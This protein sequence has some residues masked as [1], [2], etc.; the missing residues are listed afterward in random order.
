MC[1]P[2]VDYGCVR[3][4]ACDTMDAHDSGLRDASLSRR[5]VVALL[6]STAAAGVTY[7]TVGTKGVRAQVSADGLAVEDDTY[8]A[9]D[10]EL[11]SPRLSVESAWSYEGAEDATQVMV[12]LLVDGT[13]LESSI[14]DTVGPSDDGTATLAAPVVESRAWEQGDWSPPADGKVSHE[15]TVE[16]RLE[17]RDGAGETLADASAEDSATITVTDAGPS[18]TATVGGEGHVS[19]LPSEDGTPTG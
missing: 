9:P 3:E 19:F 7:V 2:A 1:L 17:V 15:V 16:L 12:A 6:G 8:A 18:V 5:R 14:T 13:L 11:Y 10:G 4:G